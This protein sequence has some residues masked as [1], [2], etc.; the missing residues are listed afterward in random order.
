M[1]RIKNCV[2]PEA[3]AETY[4]R[5]VCHLIGTAYKKGKSVFVN[6]SSEEQLVQMDNLLWTFKDTGFV[7]HHIYGS[8]GFGTSCIHLGFN[9][10]PEEKYNVC[11]NLHE[12]SVIHS[13]KYQEVLQVIISDEKVMS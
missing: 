10:E 3:M 12:K 11:V 9:V 5:E 13:D 4:L 8:E 6:V 2:Y 1:T 7:P